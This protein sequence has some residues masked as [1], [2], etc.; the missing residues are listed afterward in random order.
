MSQ[1]RTYISA[2]YRMSY[3][4]GCHLSNIF[5][6]QFMRKMFRRK[7]GLYEIV[8]DPVFRS[9]T[10]RNVTRTLPRLKCKLS[11]QY[12]ARGSWKI[13]RTTFFCCYITELPKKKSQDQ[14]KWEVVWH[15][16]LCYYYY[17]CSPNSCLS[18]ICYSI[19]LF[20]SSLYIRLKTFYK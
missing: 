4:T 8:F 1:Q 14:S 2:R 10:G 9:K 6:L 12:N 20:L 5:I 18:S 7:I 3:S 15:K 19:F 16:H 11:A 17:Q 13:L